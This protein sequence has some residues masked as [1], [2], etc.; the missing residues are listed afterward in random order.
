MLIIKLK[1][2]RIFSAFSTAPSSGT[3]TKP[4]TFYAALPIIDTALLV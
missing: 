4:F 2:I 3:A 1:L